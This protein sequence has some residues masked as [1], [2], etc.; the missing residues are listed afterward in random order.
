[1]FFS[2]FKSF[3]DANYQRSDMEQ[4][5]SATAKEN[6]RIEKQKSLI[7]EQL[8]EVCLVIYLFFFVVSFGILS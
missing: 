2:I 5:K 7:E 3:K 6:E 1:M 4:L 8:R